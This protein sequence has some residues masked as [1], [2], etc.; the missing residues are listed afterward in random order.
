MIIINLDNCER[1][2]Y[3]KCQR[4]I[5]KTNRRR[6]KTR[7]WRCHISMATSGH[8]VLPVKTHIILCS[9]RLLLQDAKKQMSLSRLEMKILPKN[10]FRVFSHHWWCV[11]RKSSVGQ[12]TSRD[13]RL[14]GSTTACSKT[15]LSHTSDR[16]LVSHECSECEM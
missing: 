13:V 11:T 16:N 3:S 6:A 2:A 9:H 10:V 8:S 12:G 14:R 1:V 7:I 15:S 4:K 5:L